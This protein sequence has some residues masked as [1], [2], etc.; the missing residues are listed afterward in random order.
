MKAPSE[1]NVR[2]RQRATEKRRAL[3]EAHIRAVESAAEIAARDMRT[4]EELAGR[5]MRR[6]EEAERCRLNRLHFEVYWSERYVQEGLRLQA[7][8]RAARS[9]GFTDVA[10]Y[11][12]AL[13]AARCRLVRLLVAYAAQ[14][15]HTAILAKYPDKKPRAA[16]HVVGGCRVNP[17]MVALLLASL[18]SK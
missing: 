10:R 15:A 14:W 3:Q 18:P 5:H 1:R 7:E 16:V 13:A 2:N 12:S 6:Y 17:V 11:R 9:E 4:A 8:Y